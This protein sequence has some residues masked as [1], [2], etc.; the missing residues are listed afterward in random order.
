MN[1]SKLRNVLGILTV[2]AMLSPIVAT[3]ADT[4]SVDAVHSSVVF[5]VKHLNTSHAW[6]RFNSFTGSWSID[7]ADAAGSKIEFSIKANSVDTANAARDKHLQSPDFF[8][9]VQYPTIKF[10][11]TKVEKTD[12]GYS[13]TGDITFHGVT[14]P[15]SFDL[16][17]VGAGKDM[18]GNAIAGVDAVFVLKQ[19][20][21]GITK[22]S[23]AIGD[24]VTVFVSLEGAK[25]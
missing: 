22:M 11:S 6:G 7:D 13:V 4:Y 15:I 8:N 10:E 23:A 24:N 25:K 16:S 14:K 3:A 9:A 5:R 19:S 17:P 21:F 1:M 18:R 20:D 12:K 2:I